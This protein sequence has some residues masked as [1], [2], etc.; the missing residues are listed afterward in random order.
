M[1]VRE[2][3]VGLRDLFAKRP[4]KEE[5]RNTKVLVCSLHARF[6]EL[7]KADSNTYS[8]FYPLTTA[9]HFAG[10]KELLDAIA[11]GY[12]IVHLFADLSPIGVLTDVGGNE[13]M[14]TALI[15][16][17]CDSAVKLLWLASDNT[18]DAYI[19]GFKAAG[20][21]LNLVMTINRNGLRFCTFLGQ[22]LS[23][24][25]GGETMPNAWVSISPQTPHDPRHSD[26][27][28]TIFS[29]GRGTVKLR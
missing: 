22:L 5:I 10:I 7:L 12:D 9:T 19:K 2:A 27:P 18:P 20:K 25:S 14:G 24:M 1:S 21:P 6:E 8:Q 11:G 28:V 26:L 13:L 4:Q 15:Q 29:A 17:C 16:K 3:K 23:R